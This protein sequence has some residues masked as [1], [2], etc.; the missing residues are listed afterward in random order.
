MTRCPV[1]HS[2]EPEV[3]LLICR[4]GFK[5]LHECTPIEC[6]NDEFHD[7]P[8]VGE[9]ASPET[10]SN[11]SV[12]GDV[13]TTPEGRASEPAPERREMTVDECCPLCNGEMGYQ[14]TEPD[15]DWQNCSWPG[16]AAIRALVQERFEAGWEAAMNQKNVPETRRG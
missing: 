6:D 13:H 9:R 8:Q 3:R 14:P 7:A 5:R 15:S 12:V 10:A 1:C 16:H 4:F 11:A 2:E